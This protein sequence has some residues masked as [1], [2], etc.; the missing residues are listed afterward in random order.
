MNDFELQ[1]AIVYGWTGG[2]ADK[3]KADRTDDLLIIV[4]YGM[5][6]ISHGPKLIFGDFNVNEE[7]LP[8]MQSLL[9]EGGWTDFGKEAHLWAAEPGQYICQ[10]KSNAQPSRIDFVL[11]NEMAV[12]ATHNFKVDYSKAFPAHLP[13]TITMT[14]GTPSEQPMGIRK[15]KDFVRAYKEKVLQLERNLR[16]KERVRRKSRM[17]WRN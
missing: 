16:R 6:H 3:E 13:I 10:A 14:I 4:A 9:M 2:G 1:V 5:E 8:T 15:T 12:A 11:G 7:Q 17:K